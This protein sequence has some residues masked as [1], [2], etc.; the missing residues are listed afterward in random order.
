MKVVIVDNVDSFVYNLY[1]YVGE[2][3]AEPVVVPN[4]LTP[5]QIDEMRPD[6]I[7][8]S[9]GPGKPESA[10]SCV[11]VIRRLGPRIPMMG[12]CLGHQCI[13]IAYGGVVSRAPAP[14][15]GKTSLIE[16]DGMGIYHGLSES[17]IATRYHSLAI[18]PELLPECLKVT[19]VTCEGEIMGVRHKEYPVEGVQFHPESILTD[20]GRKI[21]L[22][23][24]YGGSIKDYV[25]KLIERRDLSEA[26][27]V[28]AMRTI[29]TGKA[30]PSQI[31]SFL[32]ALRMKGESVSD[33]TAF[34]R[35]MREFAAKISPV[36]A[37]PIVDMCGTGGDA[38]KTFN[39][40][41][42]ASFVVA[43][44]GVPVAKHGNRSVTSK[45]G[46]ADV[47]EALGAKID[48]RPP[49]VEAMIEEN[50][51][52]FMFA[53]VFHASMKHV[54]ASR[55]EVGI[56]TVFNVLGPLTNPASAKRQVVGVYDA[57]LV[58]PIAKVLL[59]MG[60][61]RAMVVH[62]VGG[63]DEVSTFGRTIVGEI[64]DGTVMSYEV[65]PADF[66]LPVASVDDLKGGHATENAALAVRLLREKE[67][68]PKREIVLINA[69]CGIYVGGM[70]SSIKEGLE[71]A[72]SSIDS[73]RAYD[74][75]QQF[76]A[77]SNE[78]AI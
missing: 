77:R 38:I 49:E 14:M 6:R 3:G 58:V 1:Q 26:E 62:G 53:P 21:L 34:A 50:G 78:A 47:L 27:A 64:K 72:V 20:A 46:S 15:H 23:F 37:R 33:V 56:R 39:I 45:S 41:T 7:I 25:Q 32:T 18:K 61:E 44:A 36:T 71:M 11:D 51:F 30:T 12:V 40:S 52:G 29:M 24:L 4:T 74:V 28:D 5:E 54:A 2:L 67:Q 17:I 35:T 55:K 65:S 19:A 42:I 8:L 59:N 16:H 76:I 73:G 60:C 43:G 68:G 31:G 69:A 13:G 9:P 10:G 66:G 75:M 22:N 63:L 48:L 57:A 70:A